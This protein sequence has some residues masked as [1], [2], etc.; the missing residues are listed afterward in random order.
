MSLILSLAAAAGLLTQEPPVKPSANAGRTGSY[1]AR[2]SRPGYNYWVYVPKSYAPENP[3]GLH[4]F[5]HGQNAQGGAKNFDLWARHLLEPFNLI[6]INMEYEDGDNAADTEGK[7]KAAREAV[8]QVLA[9]Y[10]VVPGRG[11]I[12]SFSG[13]GAPHALFYDRHAGAPRGREWPFCMAALYG[14]NYWQ[15]PRHQKA[16]PMAWLVAVGHKEWTLARLGESNTQLMAALLAEASRGSCPD[17]YFKVLPEKGHSIADEDVAEAARVFRRA[18]LATAPFL[19]AGDFPEP[20]LRRAVEATNGLA[21]GKA[22]ELAEK[23]PEKVR[24]Q[25][26]AL[27]GKIRARVQAVLELSEELARKDPVLAVHYLPIFQ[28]QLQGLPEA[29]E[30]L[31]KLQAARTPAAQKALALLPAFQ[32]GFAGFFDG[33]GRLKA[34][35][36]PLLEALRD[37]A[38]PDSAL[39]RMAAEFLALR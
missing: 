14:S 26:D 16:S 3:A 38:G 7:L 33:A 30:L 1:Q 12:S 25:A 39:G 5:F 4:L 6:G 8:A 31:K 21:L 22:L 18:D 37:A 36:A 24:P 34:E 2:T 15:P 17:L 11:V 20:E 9:D 23:A 28:R 27:R 10:K 32:K 29:R 13:G 35:S 19:W